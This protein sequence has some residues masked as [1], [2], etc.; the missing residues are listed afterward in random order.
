MNHEKYGI[1]MYAKNSKLATLVNSNT[2]ILYGNLTII[3]IYKP[4]ETNWPNPFLLDYPQPA[5]I[6]N[7][8]S[9]HTE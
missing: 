6:A 4:L 3:N 7:F 5:Q 8:N 1:P 2:N 9:H